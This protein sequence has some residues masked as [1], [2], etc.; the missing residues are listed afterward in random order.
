MKNETFRCGY[1]ALVGRPN[2]GKSTLMNHLLGQKLSITSR[3]PQTTRHRIIGIKTTEHAQIVYVD[4]PGIHQQAKKAMN[5]FMNRAASS[6]IDDVHVVVFVVEAL[7]WTDED[8]MVLSA[9][10]DISVPV[11]LAVNKV[12]RLKQKE[13]LLPFLQMLHEKL[14]FS[15]VVPISAKGGTNLPQ[16]E[17][18]IIHH[19]DVSEA[20]YPEDQLTDRSSRFLAAEIVREKLM[21]NLGQELP[22]ATTVEIEKFEELERLNRI[23]A[24]IWVERDNQKS[25]VIGEKG[26]RLK[27]VG[28]QARLDMQKLFDKKVHLELWVKVK[29]GWSDDERALSSLG[30]R[31][32]H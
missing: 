16:L 29:A 5:R 22:Y 24:L 15:E 9:L 18:E 6:A 8:E 17:S 30:Y 19:L 14:N 26:E 12:D 13:E 32:D 21:R 3:K 23:H 11:I 31:D 28:Q 4:T 20:Y 27:K 25:I 1:V 2:V 10:K 7:K